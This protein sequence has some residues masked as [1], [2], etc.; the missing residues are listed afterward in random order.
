MES[1]KWEKITALLLIMEK[2]NTSRPSFKLILQRVTVYHHFLALFMG[3]GVVEW[4]VV[5]Q[6]QN[7]ILHLEAPKWTSIYLGRMQKTMNFLYKKVD[8]YC[9]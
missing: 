9:V 1:V 5:L 7:L 4:L 3:C 2:V 8:R 6:H